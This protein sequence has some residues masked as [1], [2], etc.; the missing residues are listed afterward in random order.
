MNRPWRALAAASLIAIGLTQA[1][2]TT[3]AW[4]RETLAK[5]IMAADPDGDREALRSHVLGLRE[6]AQG[7][8]GAGGGGCGCN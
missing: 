7:G 5:P 4:E 8:F 3:N 2:A 6:G 1:C